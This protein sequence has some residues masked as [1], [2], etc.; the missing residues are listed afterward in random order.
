[1]SAYRFRP[2]VFELE[3]A[4]QIEHSFEHLFARLSSRRG[5]VALDS[6]GGNPRRFSWIAFDP[7]R[8]LELPSSIEGLRAYAGQLSA[9]AGDDVPGPFA[10]GFLGALAYDLG[11]AG[12][13]AVRVAPDP[14]GTPLVLGGL[15]TDFVVFDEMRA[16]A[17]LVL[18]E[19]P[20]DGRTDVATRR[21]EI[22]AQIEAEPP[23]FAPCVASGGSVF[24]S[25]PGEFR[26]HVAALR[27]R[28]AAGDL[29]Q[30]NLSHRIERRVRGDPR[31][32]YLRLRRVNPAPYMAWMTWDT[33]NSSPSSSLPSAGGKSADGTSATSGALLSASPELLLEFDGE[34]AR[35]RPIKGTAPRGRDAE[36]DARHAAALLASAKDM[37]ELAMIVDLERNDLGTCAVPGGVHVEAFPRLETYA[38]VHHLT[39]DVTARVRPGVDAFDL[40][41]K[42]FPGGSITGAPKLAAMDAI[43][44]LERE[45]RGFFTGSLGFVDTRGRAAWNILIR[46]LVWRRTS[47][48]EGEV[49]F[50]VGSGITWSSDPAAEERETAH[51]AAGLLRALEGDAG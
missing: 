36:E 5:V 21:D 42:L 37:A 45:G 7:L 9:S 39:A 27:E 44:D 19:D 32:L 46:T 2:R 13:R 14:W 17:W 15:Y 33:S 30:A 48:E 10:G 50:H 29:Y 18:G 16:R 38:S 24:R 43:A 4:P 41:Q 23:P 26:A 22:L 20:G 49:C 25:A 1:M 3:R 28:I 40:L 47:G 6:A 11:V 31:D 34:I 8:G 35:T 51:K 12:E